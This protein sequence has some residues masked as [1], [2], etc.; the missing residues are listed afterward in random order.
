MLPNNFSGPTRGNFGPMK[1]RQ[2]R[3][4]GMQDRLGGTQDRFAGMQDRLKDMAAT[5]A[6]MPQRQPTRPSPSPSTPPPTNANGIAGAFQGVN[7]AQAGYDVGTAAIMANQQQPS[8]QFTP[9]GRSQQAKDASIQMQNDL[10]KYQQQ[11]QANPNMMG[12]QFSSSPN[13]AQIGFSPETAAARQSFDQ[14]MQNMGRQFQQDIAG[15]SPDKLQSIQQKY[16]ADRQMAV[17]QFNQQNPMF[18][19]Q[20]SQLRQQSLGGMQQLG[21]QGGM[22]GLGDTAQRQIALANLSPAQQ[23]Q[24]LQQQQGGMGGMPGQLGGQGATVLNEQQF[25]QRY[26]GMQP[27]MAMQAQ[28]ANQF[29]GQGGMGLKPQGNT[30]TGLNLGS[31]PYGSAPS[32]AM[33]IINPQSNFYLPG[34]GTGTQ[35]MGTGTQQSSLANQQ[36]QAAGQQQMAGMGNAQPLGAAAPAFANGGFTGRFGY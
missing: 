26:G 14:Q 17:N 29:G 4:G 18:E 13:Y 34:M 10:L 1:G 11:L 16:E 24:Q 36:T 5:R 35:Q 32:L 20:A 27:Q 23:M 30:G 25:M 19:Q 7:P 33:P 9:M 2:D 21:G 22:Q 8:Q 12:S 15:A 6:N 3:L 31:G 28:L